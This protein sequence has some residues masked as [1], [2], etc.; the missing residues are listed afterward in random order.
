MGILDNSLVIA[1][2]DSLE[3]PILIGVA[4]GNMTH[5]NL[6]FLVPSGI[7]AIIIIL[8]FVYSR[9]A[10]IACKQIDLQIKAPVFQFYS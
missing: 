6:W 5:I 2:I 8:F 10:F 7:L 4:I 3:G 9:P 1:F